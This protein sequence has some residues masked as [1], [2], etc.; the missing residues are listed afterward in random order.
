MFLNPTLSSGIPR[1]VKNIVLHANDSHPDI[2]CVP[3]FYKH[4][5][6]YKVK[7]PIPG[8]VELVFAK[9]QGSFQRLFEFFEARHSVLLG[10]SVTTRFKF[11]NFLKILSIRVV[12]FLVRVARFLSKILRTTI[13]GT[14]R[15]DRVSILEDD[16]IVMLDASWQKDTQ[17]RVG[18]AKACGTKVVCVIH[19]L[20]PVTHPHLFD[21][22]LIRNYNL[23]LDW[24]IKTAD[25]YMAVSKSTRDLA[26]TLI[27]EKLPTQDFAR[28]WFDYFYL[29]SELNI[30]P[31]SVVRDSV[32]KI[33]DS[34]L[35]VYLMVSTIEP[36]KNHEYLLDAFSEL[37]DK[38]QDLILC[39]VGRIGWKC[40]PLLKRIYSHREL[41][42]RLFML[43]DLNDTELEYAYHKSRALVFSSI[44][45]GFGLPVVEAMQRGLP[46]MVS[47]IPVFREIGG[48]YCAYFKLDDHRSLCKLVV[49]FESTEE[50]P[51]VKPLIDYQ[52][53]TWR[54]ATERFLQKINGHIADQEIE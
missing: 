46:V 35:P 34:S 24:V 42:K 54:Q 47:D 50:F 4:N 10:A 43:N 40:E 31:G 37:W 49:Q 45:E 33:F 52:W 30:T 32:K 19:D 17:K 53:L 7:R 25:G 22:K 11:F 23:W 15:G 38:D 36:R 2:E 14:V 21:E 3:V 5:S 44:A 12:I 48:K 26:K 41:N 28:R 6:A 27:E 8:P 20:I 51:A 13:A 39:F 18:I 16:V 29:G 1:V 9:A